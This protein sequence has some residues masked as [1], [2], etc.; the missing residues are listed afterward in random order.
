MDDS[1]ATIR[2]EALK[3]VEQAADLG[4]LDAVRVAALGKKGSVTGLMKTLGTLAPAERKEFGARVNIKYGNDV[5]STY[6][7]TPD[8]RRLTQANT[9]AK[10]VTGAA[11]QAQGLN[12]YYDVLGNV[13][14][15][16]QG[17]AL[18]PTG[19]TVPVGG[20]VSEWFS[21]DPIN[22][23]TS[24]SLYTQ[25]TATADDYGGVNLYYDTI[26]NITEK[27]QTDGGDIQRVVVLRVNEDARDV[28]RILEADVGP[29][30]SAVG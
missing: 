23:L 9:M 10:D 11:R 15:R 18:D 20:Y 12:L 14:G 29:A 24:A 5:V 30:A 21:Y 22:Q 6:L 3:A 4:A 17:L 7:Y 27:D 1:L 25:G 16:Y 28:A 26:G 2:N 13:T 19:E 8:T